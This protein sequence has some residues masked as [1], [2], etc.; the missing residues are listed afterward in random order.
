M[1]HPCD[2]GMCGNSDCDDCLSEVILF[3]PSQ[4]LTDIRMHNT[5]KCSRT[6]N[7]FI[8]RYLE[9]RHPNSPKSND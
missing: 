5:D 9:N 8:Q 6:N 1:S 2:W 3:T 7:T 4:I